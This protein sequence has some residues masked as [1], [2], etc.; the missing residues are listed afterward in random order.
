MYYAYWAIALVIM[1]RNARR[2]PLVWSEML[3]H[4]LYLQNARN[5]RDM[6][7]WSY[8]DGVTKAHTDAPCVLDEEHQYG[9]RL[10]TPKR[11]RAPGSFLE[12]S[13]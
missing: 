1:R 10:N 7:L 3:G 4:M 5:C 9:G 13:Q 6:A 2:N 11:Y 8:C 12:E